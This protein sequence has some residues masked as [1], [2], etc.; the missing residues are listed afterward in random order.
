MLLVF[1]VGDV[2]LRGPL[3]AANTGEPLTNQRRGRIMANTDL[4]AARLRGLLSYNPASGIF[5]RLTSSGKGSRGQAGAV[6]GHISNS[7]GGYCKIM[8][9]GRRY[10]AH[11]LAWMHVHG[12]W[13]THNIDHIDGNPLNNRIENLRDATIAINTQN[14]RIAQR[15]NKTGFLGVSKHKCGKFIASI[16]VNGERQYLGIHDTAQDAHCAYLKAKR[17]LHPGCTI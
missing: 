4:T 17:D 9:D 10:S 6:V 16:L 14:Q 13:P 3:S 2:K 15:R 5:T 8:L 7:S 11:R 12:D 1:A